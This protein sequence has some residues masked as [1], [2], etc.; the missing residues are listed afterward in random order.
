[1]ISRRLLRIKVLQ[2]AYAYFK[3]DI[4]TLA[5]SEKELFF[6]IGKTYELYL[7]LYMLIIDI[8]RYARQRIELAHGK[9]SPTYEDMHPNM[10]FAEN[11]LVSHL[12][13]HELLNSLF[14]KYKITWVNNPELTRELYNKLLASEFYLAYMNEEEASWKSDK[15]FILEMMNELFLRSESLDQVLEERS[16]YWNDD[17][18]FTVRMAEKSLKKYS[19]P[20][21]EPIPVYSLFKD[22]DDR[23]FVKRLFH[24]IVLHHEEYEKLIDLHTRNW[25]V[26][27]I[28]YMDILILELAIAE[29]LE[30]DSIPVKV[31]FNEYIEIAKYYSTEKSSNFIN[32]ILDKII[33]QLRDE[34]RIT[35]RG[36]GLIGES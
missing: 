24:N 25:D 23:E 14:K 13:N 3:S 20:D 16:I 34:N 19:G 12:E 6:S 26:E 11:L 1:M 31:S 7:S 2:I 9:L 17:L 33:Q 15:N 8:A 21:S 5:K 36:R 4:D 35:K 29:I 27:R 28:A 10:R 22:D 18:E 30:N 32:G